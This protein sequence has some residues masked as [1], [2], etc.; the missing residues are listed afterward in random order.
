MV[1]LYNRTHHLH[2]LSTTDHHL[3]AFKSYGFELS[4]LK[5][6]SKL[7][8]FVEVISLKPSFTL[9]GPPHNTFG[10]NGG[11]EDR[12]CPPGHIVTHIPLHHPF[13][14]PL[15]CQWLSDPHRS[16]SSQ[17]WPGSITHTVPLEYNSESFSEC[18]TLLL[19]TLLHIC[20]MSRFQN[21][22]I[23]IL[24]HR[25]VKSGDGRW[26]NLDNL[27]RADIISVTRIQWQCY[28]WPGR[29][30]CR[31]CWWTVMEEEILPD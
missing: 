17:S 21:H 31:W 9:N 14:A 12:P 29:C 25:C 16:L 23:K 19:C 15:P 4:D 18:I 7:M 8:A 20:S 30:D 2:E 10:G 6:P 28:N 3:L 22:D 5:T 27:Y 24:H 26:K 13:G 1:P 11:V